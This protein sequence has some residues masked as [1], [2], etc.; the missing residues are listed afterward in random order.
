MP[1]EVPTAGANHDRGRTVEELERELDEANR[2]EAATADV[3]RV[4]SKSPSDVQ[5]VFE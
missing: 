1:P 3:L 5:P 4:I 2:R